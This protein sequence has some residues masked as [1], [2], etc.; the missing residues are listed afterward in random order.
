[1]L[2]DL[3]VGFKLVKRY[4]GEAFTK[5]LSNECDSILLRCPSHGRRI[6]K[7]LGP[8]VLAAYEALS[9]LKCKSGYISLHQIGTEEDQAIF[10]AR[11]LE[12]GVG[13]IARNAEWTA[14]GT[15]L[16][17]TQHM[18]GEGVH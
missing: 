12:V 17:G 10:S 13:E 6:K 16:D 15:S 8:R 2:S 9:H 5:A 3:D 4:D 1:M 11:T 18:E 7:T 14:I